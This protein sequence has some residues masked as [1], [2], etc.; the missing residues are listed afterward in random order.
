MVNQMSEEEVYEE[1]KKR[2][3]AKKDFYNHLGAWVLVN[4]VLVVV[5]ALTDHGGHPWFLY[6]LCIWGIFILSHFVQTFVIKPK[7]DRGA[8]EKEAE[9]IRKE[10]G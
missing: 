1:A 9:K 4:I 5:W 2:V 3:K 7:S 6:P 8:I 10:R